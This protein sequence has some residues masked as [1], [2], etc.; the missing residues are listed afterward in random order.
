MQNPPGQSPSG[1]E[2]NGISSPFRWI[3]PLLAVGVLIVIFIGL[4][5]FGDGRPSVPYTFFK[6]ELEREN[7]LEV[8]MR[9]ETVEGDFVWA[10]DVPGRADGPF[11]RFRTR[12]P[13]FGDETLLPQLEE[14]GVTVNV[15]AEGNGFPWLTVLLIGLPIT[16]IIFMF[17]RMRSI[18]NPDE[19]GQQMLSQLGK[20][21]ARRY[22]GSRA[23]VT[24]DDVQGADEAKRELTQVVDFL[25]DPTRFH[26]V[27]A[28]MPKGILLMGSPGTGKTLLAKAVAGEAGV[29][30]FSI[31]GSEFMEVYV[32]LGASRVRDLFKQA[33]ESMP[34]IIF[35]DEIDAVGRQRGTGLGGGHDERE[36]T[37][38][39]LLA[40]MD[41]FEGRE[42]VV[43]LAATNRP[44]VLDP[45]L[46]RPGRFDRRVIMDL[47]D[48]RGREAILRVHVKEVPLDEDVDLEALARSLPG[49]AGADLSNLVNEAAILAAQEGTRKVSS[50]H[51]AQARERIM[52]GPRRPL[53]L[54]DEQRE[55]VAYHESGHAL[56]AHFLPHA[57]P[58]EVVSIVPHSQALGITQQS[59]DEERY[60]Y[61]R[62]TLLERLAV[63]LGGRAAEKLIG[64]EPTTGSESD[65]KEATKLARRMVVN[66]G[67]SER[68]GPVSFDA[69]TEHPFLGREL[70]SAREYSEQTASLVDEEVR[71]MI[72]AA[73]RQALDVLR[74]HEDKLHDVV[75]T[76]QE[77]ETL[78]RDRFEAILGP[79]PAKASRV[80]SRRPASVGEQ[81]S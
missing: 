66:W 11:E 57:D 16:L 37:L 55:L 19:R 33:K 24:F 12:V 49:F 61:D 51:F 10:V 41:G 69:G 72:E 68:I 4:L 77:E 1:D 9:G 27:G 71:A 45:A 21:G 65:L 28:H 54:S 73:E 20:A 59:P 64:D 78:A 35:V 67:M 32:G 25:R 8:T 2:E 6:S 36:Q 53:L 79:K 76:L 50:E 58:V 14:A 42:S 56:V 81:S 18:A 60:N 7:I 40:E 30:F 74:E 44:D 3:L 80:L 34:S 63:M 46:V 22:E 13:A 15:E 43:V 31:S 23:R 48:R 29:P 5:N 62:R 17:L 38:N 47:P 39:Q 70:Q 26:S 52:L 75:L